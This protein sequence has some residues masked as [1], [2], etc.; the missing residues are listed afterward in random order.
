[1]LSDLAVGYLFLGGAGAGA[2]LVLAAMGLFVPRAAAF[3]PV[4]ARERLRPSPAHRR[5]LAPGFA[6]AL[7]A[8]AGGVACLVADVGS[9]DRAVLLFA[10]PAWTHLA[11][12]AWSL[13]AC[14]ALG[15]ALGLAWAGAGSW[16]VVTFRVLCAVEAAAALVAMAY[17]GLLLQSLAAVPL[18]TPLLVPVLFVLSAAS[19]GIALVLGSAQ[20]SGAA[21]VFRSTMRRL[22][23]V[24]AGIV[25]V[26]ALVAAAFVLAARA[27]SGFPADTPSAFAASASAATLVSGELAWL[28]WG[29]FAAAGLAVP[30]A[31]DVL[32]ARARRPM[33]GI[34]LAAA[35]CVLVGGLIMRYCVVEAGMRPLLAFAGG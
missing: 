11:V 16:S 18:W 5:L 32:L 21:M 14:L 20:L 17:T 31:L 29:G 15:C 34:A 13:A 7:V 23:A 33:P 2:C 8:L 27:G 3:A 10:Q 4:G 22:V 12:G 19:C 35:A 30:F 24:D 28:F 1:M 6:A 26:E 25:V 9:I